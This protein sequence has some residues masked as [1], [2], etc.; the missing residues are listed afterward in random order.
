[1]DAYKAI[2]VIKPEQYEGE[3]CVIPG[4][5]LEHV[6]EMLEA[7]EGKP[8]TFYEH[9]PKGP[10]TWSPGSISL[11][12]EHFNMVC[13]DSRYVWA[14]DVDK[15]MAQTERVDPQR[16]GATV[17]ICGTGSDFV[18]YHY[19]IKIREREWSIPFTKKAP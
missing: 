10:K 19:I 14:K 5:P 18:P 9:I 11:E 3:F 13:V 8:I 1:M 4:M 6:R 7:I 17:E 12:D 15:I 16:D 2:N